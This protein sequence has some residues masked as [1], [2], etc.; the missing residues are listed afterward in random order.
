MN[1]MT[2][3][4]RLSDFMVENTVP[5]VDYGSDAAIGVGLGMTLVAAVVGGL[6]TLIAYG[7]LTTGMGG[8]VRGVSAYDK[9]YA[10]PDRKEIRKRIES[11]ERVTWREFLFP[12]K[13]PQP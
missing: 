12:E 13:S 10:H 8:L 3:T 11:G 5:I 7:I 4:K 6:P 1:K 2:L 9:A